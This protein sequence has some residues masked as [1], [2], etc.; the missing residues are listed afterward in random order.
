M[1]LPKA[2]VVSNAGTK[3][4]NGIYKATSR[5]YCDAPVYEH[6]ERGAELKLTREPHKN[7]KTGVIK[8]GWLLGQ[9]KMPLYGAPTELLVVP[10]SG[11]KKFS[12]GL[13]VPTIKVQD[14]VHDIFYD[15]A[16][17]A[18]CAGDA[19]AEK[20]D[21][22]AARSAF[23]EGIDALKQSGERFGEAFQ[24]RA[25]LLLGRRA[26]ANIKMQESRPALRDAVAALELM[27]SLASAEA[28]VIQ[29]ARALGCSSDSSMEKM[30]EHLGRGK[31]LDPGAPL[32]LR[33]VERWT[34]DWLEML[35]SEDNAA[36]ALPTATHLQADRY[37]DGLT[38]EQRTQILRRYLPEALPQP[39]G[40][41][42]VLANPRECLDVMKQW[43]EVLQGD[44]F[45]QMRKELWEQ[46]GIS[47]VNRLLQS[48]KLMWEVLADVNVPRGFAEGQ[49]GLSRCIQQ[50]RPWWSVDKACARKALDL[51][52][53]A[54]ISLAD[55]EDG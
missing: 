11:W 43:Q 26:T 18:K 40:G 53:L 5:E 38:E 28:V 8:H 17:E 9:N 33:C 31:I 52:E 15:R 23:S 22:A 39:D 36:V 25:A 48:R 6:M 51:E 55:L 13:P 10:T 32:V 14:E 47:Y 7:A 16:D 3:E 30:L 44:N 50:M 35:L 19:A 1:V 12:G 2:V 29:A 21:W 46:Q 54:D 45:Q 34:E 20:E 49:P 42:A 27:R 41:S 37:L 4:A 24:S